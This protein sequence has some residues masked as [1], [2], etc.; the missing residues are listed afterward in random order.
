MDLKPLVRRAQAGEE[1]SVSLVEQF[2][3]PSLL[4]KSAQ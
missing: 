1:P 3:S 4:R 2:A